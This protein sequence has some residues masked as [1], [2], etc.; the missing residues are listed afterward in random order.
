MVNNVN[1]FFNKMPKYS[2]LLL[3][4]FCKIH[5]KVTLPVFKLCVNDLLACQTYL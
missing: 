4:N 1:L 3:K 2:Y 5:V